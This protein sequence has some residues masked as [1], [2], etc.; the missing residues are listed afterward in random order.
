MNW[1][2]IAYLA[3]YLVLLPLIAGATTM[4]TIWLLEKYAS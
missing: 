3:F 1:D 4:G 2:L